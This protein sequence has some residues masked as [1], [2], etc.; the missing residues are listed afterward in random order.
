MFLLKC[1]KSRQNIILFSCLFQRHNMI[2]QDK[3]WLKSG[4]LTRRQR[5]VAILENLE[6]SVTLSMK[7][8]CKIIRTIKVYCVLKS[9]LYI[10]QVSISLNAFA[11]LFNIIST[12]IYLFYFKKKQ[13]IKAKLKVLYIYHISD[14][15]ISLQTKGVNK[16]KEA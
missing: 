11:Y 6:R 16:R 14:I 9:I 5:S 8:S 13:K 7:F 15:K 3:M 4:Y 12:T 10:M 2:N 1:A